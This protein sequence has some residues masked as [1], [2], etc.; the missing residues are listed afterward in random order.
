M[1]HAAS[2]VHESDSM[3]QPAVIESEPQSTVEAQEP[4]VEPES[5]DEEPEED[6]ATK[7]KRIA[8][9]LAKSGGFNPFSG[10]PPRRQSSLVSSDLPEKSIPSAEPGVG[11]EISNPDRRDS[12]RKSSAD[13]F[14]PAPRQP[15]RQMSSSSITHERRSSLRQGSTDSGKFYEHPAPINTATNE[16]NE[17]IVEVGNEDGESLS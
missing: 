15:I 7:R 12:Y 6:E 11:D 3:G 8:E 9:R 2:A 10:P 16:V 4:Q 5:V 14:D 17:A 1:E 13:S